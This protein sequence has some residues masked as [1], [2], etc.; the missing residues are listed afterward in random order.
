MSLLSACVIP[1]TTKRINKNDLCVNDL[2]LRSVVSFRKAYVRQTLPDRLLL[3]ME[4]FVPQ[5]FLLTVSAHFASPTL[6]SIRVQRAVVSGQQHAGRLGGTSVW[7]AA[8]CSSA[9]MNAAWRSTATM[10]TRR[11]QQQE[12]GLF[13]ISTGLFYMN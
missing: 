11:T 10:E 2:D 6:N 7:A 5:S 9:V 1:I 13:L 3:N 4:M 12:R 8:N